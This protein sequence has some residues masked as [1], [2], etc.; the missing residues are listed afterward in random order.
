MRGRRFLALIGVAALV[1][2]LTISSTTP[3]SASQATVAAVKTLTSTCFP[4]QDNG[5]PVLKSFDFSP[6]DVDSRAG[7]QIVTFRATAEDTGGP[8]APSGVVRAPSS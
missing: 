2:P 5:D 7:A 3:A 8:G 4:S 6:R 1:P